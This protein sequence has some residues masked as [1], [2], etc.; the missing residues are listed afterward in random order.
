MQ[1]LTSIYFRP[2]LLLTLLVMS[3]FTLI[4]VG[5]G[6]ERVLIDGKELQNEKVITLEK[7]DTVYLEAYGIKPQSDIH[8]KVMK[9]G[10]KWAE[11]SYHVDESGMIKAIMHVPEQKL[12]V[13]CEVTYFGS[14]GQF[15]EKAFKFKVR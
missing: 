2:A 15:I 1:F 10:I 11:D 3:S 8:V 13:N 5:G 9:L 12:T 14:N 7:D 4:P 6:E